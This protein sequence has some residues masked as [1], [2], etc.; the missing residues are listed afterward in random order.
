MN[1]SLKGESMVINGIK[2]A[3]TKIHLC[4]FFFEKLSCIVIRYWGEG[5]DEEIVGCC[6]C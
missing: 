2:K 5:E 3:A 1:A 6:L 4:P